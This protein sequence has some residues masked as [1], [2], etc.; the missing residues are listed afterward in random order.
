MVHECIEK[1]L[2]QRELIGV[3][4]KAVLETTKKR[5]RKARMWNADREGANRGYYILCY[6]GYLQLLSVN[7]Y[8]WSRPLIL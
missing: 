7:D 8:I 1:K 6:T 4:K 3:Q 5:E 2:A